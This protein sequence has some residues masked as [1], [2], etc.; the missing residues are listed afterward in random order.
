M[1]HTHHNNIYRQRYRNKLASF[2]TMD[3]LPALV[4]QPEN[5]TERTGLLEVCKMTLADDGSGALVAA[6]QF[7]NENASCVLRRRKTK[8]TDHAK[9]L[10]CT[11][12]YRQGRWRDDTPDAMK[13]ARVLEVLRQKIH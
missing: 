10:Q 5:V 6:D 9:N 11:E 12:A 3:R 8:V 4:E 1:Q 13:A 2:V 7:H